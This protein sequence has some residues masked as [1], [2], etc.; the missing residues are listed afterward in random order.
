[1]YAYNK[2]D[3]NTSNF[4]PLDIFFC[5][6]LKSNQTYREKVIMHGY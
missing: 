6:N 1:M 2:T 4:T 5:S 3:S